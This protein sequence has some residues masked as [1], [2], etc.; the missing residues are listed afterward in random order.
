[1]RVNFERQWALVSAMNFLQKREDVKREEVPLGVFTLRFFSV[2][3]HAPFSSRV[4]RTICGMSMAL[5]QI[6]ERLWRVPV[7][8]VGDLMLD[9][10]CT[11]TLNVSRRGAGSRAALPEENISLGR[12]P[13]VACRWLPW[14]RRCGPSGS[15]VRTIPGGTWSVKFSACGADTQRRAGMRRPPHRLQK[16]ASSACA[17]SPSPADDPHLIEELFPCR[18]SGP[19]WWSRLEKAI[20]GAR[21]FA[22]GLQQ[23]PAQR[24]RLSAHDRHR[25][26]ACLPVLVDPASISEYARYRGATAIK[27]NRLET[28]K[29]SRLPVQEESQFA[30]AAEWLLHNLDL[31]AAIITLDK[32]GSYLGTRD[33][34]RRWL[35]T[36]PGRCMM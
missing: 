9:R 6:M 2:F 3:P 26:Q 29:A 5:V 17:A 30:P 25:P 16:P 10:I 11:V 19:T 15:S 24:R 28:E 34:E 22:R 1:M 31:E 36:R 7:V 12:A 32:H 4:Y 8:L 33:G 13:G 18:K 14:A 20:D 23:G 27:L 21:W 35:K